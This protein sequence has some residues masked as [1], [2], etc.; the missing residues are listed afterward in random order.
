MKVED[1]KKLR[2]MTSLGVKDCKNALQEASGDVDKALT[3][4][5]QKGIR[6]MEKRQGR[7]AQQGRIE[8]Y[9]HFGG[10]LGVLVEVNCETDFVART[11]VFKAFTKDIAMQVAAASPVYVSREEIPESEAEGVKDIEAYAK[12]YCL[13]DQQ[14]IK[15]SKLTIAEYLKNIVSQTGEKVVIRRFVRFVVGE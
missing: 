4:L 12:Q 8:S 9:V 3:I 11:D 15:D 6:M 7:V 1:V 5:R 13:L 2:E 14:F 10:N